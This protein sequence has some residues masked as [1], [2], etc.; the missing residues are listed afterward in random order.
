[1]LSFEGSM[2]G[3]ISQTE[4]NTVYHSYVESKKKTELAKT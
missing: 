3:E 2:L 1:M 4:A